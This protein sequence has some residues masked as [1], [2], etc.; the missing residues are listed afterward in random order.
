M[1]VITISREPY[2]GGITLGAKI[3]DDLGYPLFTKKDFTEIFKEYGL[4]SFEDFYESP[5]TVWERIDELGMEYMN[6]LVKV[7][8]GIGAMDNAVILGRGSFAVFPDFRDVINVRFWAPAETRIARCMEKEKTDR[9]SARK[10]VEEKDKLRRSFI[11]HCFHLH[12]SDT[13]N[14][15]DVVLNTSKVSD[16][17]ALQVI[18]G[19]MEQLKA[20]GGEGALT[21][22]LPYDRT[23]TDTISKVLSNHAA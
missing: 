8:R 19:T 16:A 5:L 21:K 11:T 17:G 1:A 23:L 10:I 7:I 2:S 20:T 18:R 12:K 6:F 13:A 4:I 14:A 3:A 9:N 15:F 22:N